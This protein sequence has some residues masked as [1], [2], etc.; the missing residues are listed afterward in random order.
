MKI[1]YNDILNFLD[2]NPSI[3]D[4]SEKLFQLGHENEIINRNHLDIEITPNRGDCLSVRGISRDLGA[5]YGFNN[6]MELYDKNINEIELD[7]INSSKENCP[8]ISFLVIDIS[9]VPQKYEEFLENYFKVF[10]SKKNN[11]FTDIS[12]Y[13]AYEMGQPIHCYDF[14]TINKTICL[15]KLSEGSKFKTLIG[16]EIK[17][18]KNDL[19]F[20]CN[21]E[22]INLAG[23]MGGANTSC[24]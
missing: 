14:K 12:N 24:T 19:V 11:F 5:F 1:D 4:V 3:N 13:V 2:E 22:I 8:K 21:K 17:I 10:Q 9:K 7:F 23:V 6:N 18:D 15:E 16:Q 20:K